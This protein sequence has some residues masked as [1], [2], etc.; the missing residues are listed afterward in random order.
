[1]RVE[2]AEHLA[3]DASA[4]AVLAAGADTH[5]VHGVKNPAMHRFQ[6]VADVGQRPG[7]YHAHRIRQIRRA[8]LVFDGD[9]GESTVGI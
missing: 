1:M 6:A 9:I 8:H 2:L 3:H 4:F 5:V 7:H